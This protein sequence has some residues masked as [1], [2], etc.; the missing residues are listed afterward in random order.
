MVEAIDKLLY[1]LFTAVLPLEFSFN[2]QTIITTQMAISMALN[3]GATWNRST[4]N[5][6]MQYYLRVD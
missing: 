3:H 4:W 2:T 1:Q 6:F 5:I